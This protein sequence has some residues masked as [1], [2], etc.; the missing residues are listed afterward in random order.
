MADFPTVQLCQRA[1]IAIRVD[2][3]GAVDVFQHG[4]I[5]NGVAIAVAMGKLQ[6]RVLLQPLLQADDLTLL[7][8]HG[9]VGLAGKT[10][11]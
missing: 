2:N 7:I 5:V 11:L 8:G 4:F 9:A 6:F 1:K 3:G 10:A